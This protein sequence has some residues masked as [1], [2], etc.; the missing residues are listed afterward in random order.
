VTVPLS[1]PFSCTSF[2][3]GRID[4][5]IPCGQRIG[6]GGEKI[7]T[8]R[9]A[10]GAPAQAGENGPFVSMIALQKPQNLIPL[11]KPEMQ[12]A[13]FSRN[14]AYLAYAAV[15]GKLKQRRRSDFFSGIIYEIHSARS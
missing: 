11:K 9:T 10:C 5:S 13:K 2:I 1:P 12:D 7:R 3:C 15:T 14:E 4:P 8:C 6:H